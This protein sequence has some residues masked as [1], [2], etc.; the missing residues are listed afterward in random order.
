[1]RVWVHASIHQSPDPSIRILIPKIHTHT[2]TQNLFSSIPRSINPNTHFGDSHAHAHA[3]AEACTAC[4]WCSCWSR[5]RQL[6]INLNTHFEDTHAHAHAHAHA[7]ACTA[8]TW[9]SC[10][11]RCRQRQFSS[12]FARSSF[13]HLCDTPCGAGRRW[14]LPLPPPLL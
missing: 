5:C 13:T 9:C 2:H 6:S 12:S 11:S 14:Q 4:T 7:E 1:M 8:C 3:H 10:W